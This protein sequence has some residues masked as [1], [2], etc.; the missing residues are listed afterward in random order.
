MTTF[1]LPE[2][3]QIDRHIPT[4]YVIRGYTAEQ[5]QAAYNQGRIDQR[6][7]QEELERLYENVRVAFSNKR[8]T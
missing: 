3:V 4:N 1:K 7:E 6:K 5:M 8:S 2:P